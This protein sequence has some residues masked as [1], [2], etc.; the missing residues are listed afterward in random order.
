MS[1]K[2]QPRLLYDPEPRK[3]LSLPPIV[4]PK[5]ATAS[6]SLPKSEDAGATL[7]EKIGNVNLTI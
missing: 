1:E 5:K 4:E 6:G 2:K 7:R 3:D